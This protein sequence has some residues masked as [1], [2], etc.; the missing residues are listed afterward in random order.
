MGAL[1]NELSATLRS[2]WALLQAELGL[3]RRSLVALVVMTGL[4]VLFV[5]GT[6]IGVLLL[7]AA[8][9]YRISGS[10]LAAAAAVL[11]SNVVAAAATVWRM[12]R[13]ARDLGL[14]RSRAALRQLGVGSHEKNTSGPRPG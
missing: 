7:V 10:L 1:R 2:A 11:A 6:W 9:T 4:M 3:A 14:P 5:L 13:A 8:T 12:K